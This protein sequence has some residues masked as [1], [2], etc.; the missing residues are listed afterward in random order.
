MS[1]KKRR[2]SP[3]LPTAP[4]PPSRRSGWRLLGLLATNGVGWILSIRGR[5]S[6]LQIDI[7]WIIVLSC[8][9]YLLWT[10]DWSRR[11]RRLH[12]LTFGLTALALSCVAWWVLAR[13]V[14]VMP[15]P[16]RTAT[17]SEIADAVVAKL[18]VGSITA[19]GK[20]IQVPANNQ[21][22]ERPTTAPEKSTTAITLRWLFEVR[23]F[24]NLDRSRAEVGVKRNDNGSEVVMEGQLYYNF[25]MK[26]KFIGMYIPRIPED[27]D[28]SLTFELVKYWADHYE[29][30]LAI[31]PFAGAG[32]R[33]G[34]LTRFEDLVFTGRIYVYHENPLTLEQ[35][36]ALRAIYRAKDKNIEVMFRG[37]DY[38]GFNIVTGGR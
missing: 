7:I 17:A 34:E 32:G 16:D 28:S 30:I 9:L 24:D 29:E 3:R 12:R 6:Q 37:P 5:G 26:A 8:N 38:L 13:V 19:A 35:V 2:D 1:S 23:D 10:S 20:V 21:P 25:F 15:P 36:V 31:K 4:P 18:E 22:Q 11:L 14:F 33:I 27:K